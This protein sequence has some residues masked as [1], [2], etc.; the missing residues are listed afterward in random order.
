MS[1][2]VCYITALC[3]LAEDTSVQARWPFDD[4]YE[5]PS[6]HTHTPSSQSS[7]SSIAA[8]HRTQLHAGARYNTKFV[9]FRKLNL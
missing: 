5:A 3:V 9:Y 4:I 8:R 2:T 6:A 1:V 7:I